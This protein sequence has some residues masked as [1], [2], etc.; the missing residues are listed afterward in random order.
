[1]NNPNKTAR[2]VAKNTVVLY[3]QRFFAAGLSLITTPIILSALGVADYGLYTLVIGFVGML[4]FLNWSLSSATQ[5]YIAF[6]IGQKDEKRIQNVFVTSLFIHLCYGILFLVLLVTLGNYFADSF[7][8][9][10]ED[11]VVTAQTLFTIVAGITFFTILSIPFLGVLRAHENFFLI[12]VTG[13]TESTLK[14]GIALLLLVATQDKLLFYAKLLL[15]LSL[16][17]FLIYA[18]SVKRKYTHL[19]FAIFKPDGLLIKEMLAF[20]SWSFLGALAIMSRNQG[21][22][23]LINL[24]FGVV[25]NAAYG[26]A[27]QVSAAMSILSQGIISSISPQIIKSAGAGNQERMLF[28]MRTMSKFA[29]FSVSLVVIPLFFECQTILE[30]WLPVVPEDTIT[31]IRWIMIFGQ[32]MLLSAGIQ[33]VFDALGKVREYHT[34]VSVLLLL[35]LPI[36]YLFFSLDFP[37][38]TIII[39]GMTLELCSLQVRLILLQKHVAFSIGAFYKDAVVK[40][41]FPT[42]VLAIILFFYGYLPLHSYAKVVLSFGTTLVFYPILIYK[43]ALDSKQKEVLVGLLAKYNLPF[44]RKT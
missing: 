37:A 29:V 42:L 10:P 32:V 14:L 20:V 22:Q 31:F 23:V 8:N 6:A 25:K 40:T 13:I 41:L 15:A 4:T 2:S 27:M 9:I 1:M 16:L 21:V 43:L 18:V 33:T 30:L 34:W 26:I 19:S 17:V 11:K 39:V 36:G 38:Y 12:A 5:R 3:L 24:F 44:L 28:L 7:L 35:N